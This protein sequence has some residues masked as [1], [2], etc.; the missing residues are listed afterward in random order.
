MIKFVSIVTVFFVWSFEGYYISYL[1]CTII[2]LSLSLCKLITFCL[3]SIIDVT[4]WGI[5]LSGHAVKWA[6]RILKLSPPCTKQLS[7]YLI[8]AINLPTGPVSIETCTLNFDFGPSKP[9][10]FVFLAWVW[11]NSSLCFHL[12]IYFWLFFIT[13]NAEN[14][15]CQEDHVAAIIDF[16]TIGLVVLLCV[17]YGQLAPW[18]VRPRSSHL[19]TSQLDPWSFRT[20]I[21]PKST[22]PSIFW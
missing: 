16:V 11:R 12:D 22:W 3:N 13:N 9:K 20:S 8:L 7:Y 10:H 17:G 1:Q 15:A 19:F 18:S 2:G 6:C 5:S 21:E 4:S 14:S